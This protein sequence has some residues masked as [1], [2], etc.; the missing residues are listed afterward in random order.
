MSSFH[1]Y[2]LLTLVCL[3]I[4]LTLWAQTPSPADAEATPHLR[5]VFFESEPQYTRVIFESEGAIRYSAVWLS[6]PNRLAIDLTEIE[7]EPQLKNR[8]IPVDDKILKRIH[9][10]PGGTGP[11]QARIVL[12]L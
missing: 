11:H 6:E 1:K 4:S 8:V 7:L 12:D 5:Q 3:N 10:G 2:R 9:V